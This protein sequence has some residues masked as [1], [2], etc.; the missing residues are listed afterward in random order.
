MREE[1]IKANKQHVILLI[2]FVLAFA[3]RLF[4]MTWQTYPPGADIGCH[5]TI[6]NSIM[7]PGNTDLMWNFYQMGG[8]TTPAFPGY[9]IF[10]ALIISTTGMPSFFAQSIIASLFSAFAVL[11]V[12]LVTR[13]IW[14]E[15]VGVIASIFVT[16]SRFDIEMLAWGGYPNLTA[17]FLIPLI[18]YLFLERKKMASAPFFVLVSILVASL[19]LAHSL[20]SAIFVCIIGLTLGVVFIFPKLFDESRKKIFY[21]GLPILVGILIVSPYLTNAIPLY[22][23]ESAT[24]AGATAILDTLLN[25]R[26]VPLNIFFALFACIL[27]LFLISKKYYGRLSS[28]PVF[29]LVV[30][31]LVPLLLTQS[32]LVGLYVDYLRFLYFLMVPV[33]VIFAVITDYVSRY[34]ASALSKS[35]NLIER[36]KNIHSVFKKVM[37]RVSRINQNKLYA[38]FSAVFVIILLVYLPIF[39]F[40]W[41]GV[42]I[43]NFYQSMN[44]AGYQGIEWVKQNTSEGS[45]FVSDHDYG[46]WLGG[47]GERPTISAVS[48]QSLALARE[49]NI[50]R[51]ATFMLDT[52]YMIDNGY[53]QV[54]EDGGYLG[55]HNPVFLASSNWVKSPYGFFHFNSSE[56]I[57]KYGNGTNFQSVS[58][59]DLPVM[60]M[61]L[62]D[63]NTKNPSIIVNKSIT[64]FSYSTILTVTQ[65]NIFA[66]MTIRIQ[67]NK[68]SVALE[69]LIFELNSQGAIHQSF[70]NSI[71][72]L[73]TEMNLYGQIIFTKSIPQI[74]NSGQQNSSITQL[75][76]GFEG[77]S[78]IEIQLLVGIYD[79]STLNLNQLNPMN[80]IDAPYGS[81]ENF[82]DLS[83]TTFDYEVAMQQYNVSY[84]ANRDFTL[85]PKYVE[86]QRFSLVFENSEVTI[87][88]VEPIFN[89]TKRISQNIV[90]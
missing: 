64:D 57:L 33:I 19:V 2:I 72:M 34:L 69:S 45:V 31:F 8:G 71:V 41:E 67:S 87:F 36:T 48:L 13:T 85:N 54:R 80:F 49:V 82:P 32:Y 14:N 35:T 4:L 23:N 22:L 76:Y 88:H 58:I 40:P 55:R 29:L 26:F 9:H 59:T 18:F 20:S 25:D 62:V 6:I 60:N 74:E 27:P 56:T 68:S 5:T 83:I 42:E 89:S 16:V 43:Q 44:H 63:A 84:V 39:L 66:N 30:W 77:K 50:S 12:F 15:S 81:K 7:Q 10:A 70:N 47:F 61:Q 3:Y 73:D 46:W 24:F 37:L 90:K 52:D 65:G 86:D 38:A 53:I 1:M 21:R 51:N 78:E 17:M 11:A 75:A 28:L 79:V